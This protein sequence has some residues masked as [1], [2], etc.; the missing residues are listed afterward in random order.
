MPEV[1][2]EKVQQIKREIA[3]GTYRADAGKIAE[4]IIEDR[5]LD[6]HV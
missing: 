4:G 3:S 2:E 5:L 1:R 6:K